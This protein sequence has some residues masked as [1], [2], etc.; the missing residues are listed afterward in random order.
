[1]IVAALFGAFLWWRGTL[2]E[3]RWY[4]RVMAQCWWLGFVAVIA[5]WTVTETGRQPWLVQGV[6]RTADATSPVPS[7]SIAFTLTLFVLA[8]GTV[9]SFGIY[10]INRLIAQGPQGPAAE[11]TGHFGSS[12]ISAAHEAG[13]QAVQKS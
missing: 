10:Y 7:A 8:Y 3:T 1:M 13:R 4:L 12:P 9:F 5:G 2:F 11:D 6:L